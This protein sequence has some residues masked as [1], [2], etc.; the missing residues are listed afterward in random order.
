MSL[1]YSALFLVLSFPK[2]KLLNGI[3]IS[4]FVLK[5]PMYFVVKLFQ[6]RVSRRTF[7]TKRDEIIGSWR[8]M[9][10]EDT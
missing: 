3:F 8:K 5:F 6:N 2:I 9:L 1:L 7:G 10:N 4:D